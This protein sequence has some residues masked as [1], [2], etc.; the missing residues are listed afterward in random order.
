MSKGD[1]GDRTDRAASRVSVY[2]RHLGLIGAY[3]RFQFRAAYAFRTSFWSQVASMFL[4]DGVWIAYWILFFRRFPNLAGWHENDLL[5]I[6]GVAA[7]SFGIVAVVF[8]N[9]LNLQSIIQ[10]GELDIYLSCPKPVLLHA[11]ISR[12]STTGWGDILFGLAVLLFVTPH[13]LAGIAWT[14]VSLVASAALLLG[15][16]ILTQTVGFWTGG[17]GAL[18][19]QLSNAFL[20]FQTYPPSIFHGWAAKFVIF[21]L[22]P[23]GIAAMLPLSVLHGEWPWLP[24]AALALGLF[25]LW[26]AR[27]VFYAGLRRY[28]SGNR[29]T[30]RS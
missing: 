21:I 29:I 12:Q 10:T 1:N 17:A 2:A 24:P 13:S 15:F 14:F 16:V 26:M 20:S 28:T 6:W 4:N 23:S 30:V 18:G 8:G 5:F 25:W 27:T 3:A 19:L 22:I 11:L 9:A 7:T